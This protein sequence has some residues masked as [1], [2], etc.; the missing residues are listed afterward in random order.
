METV[1]LF[2]S[3]GLLAG[4]LAGLLGI[5][6]GL[7]VVPVLF[8]YFSGYAELA[9]YAMHLALGSSLAFIVLNSSAAAW[10]HYRLD[11][12]QWPEARDLSP[13]LVAGGLIGAAI[14]DALSTAVL[15]RAFGIFLLAM[16][17]LILFGSRLQFPGGGRRWHSAAAGVPIG[18]VAALVGV[19][20]GVMIVPWLLSRGY[21]AAQAV[22]T[23]SICTIVVAVVGAVG[24]MLFADAVPLP[25]T[26]G[27]VHWPAVLGIAVTAF[28]T[29]RLGARLAHR[30]DQRVLRKV[31]AL[32]LV[33]V[34]VRL[35]I[36]S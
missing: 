3:A 29:A 30:V 35:L 5:G 10:V 22:A 12:V 25:Y 31:F 2:I 11:G 20:G 14:A 9:P 28:L 6:G 18:G 13:G 8:F 7:V 33:I 23:S 24:Y 21:R 27:Y 26:T 32:L 1:L 19:G 15:A 34:A 36:Q 16:A 4:F 17:A